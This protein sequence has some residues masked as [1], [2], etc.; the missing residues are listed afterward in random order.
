MAT[1]LTGGRR[2]ERFPI[3][4]RGSLRRNVPCRRVRDRLVFEAA[5]EFVVRFA[6]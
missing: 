3:L 5:R 4:L 2:N 6:G 1:E